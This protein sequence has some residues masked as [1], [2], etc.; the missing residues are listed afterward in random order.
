MKKNFTILLKKTFMLSAISAL[1]VVCF[2]SGYPEVKNSEAQVV[3]LQIEDEVIDFVYTDENS[4]E[5]LIIKTDEKT[6]FGL[7]SAQIYFSISNIGKNSELVNIQTYFPEDKVEIERIEKLTEDVPYE[8]DVPEFGEQ[9]FICEQGWEEFVEENE[10][11]NDNE[12]PFTGFVCSLTNEKEPCDSLSEDKKECLV[13]NVY[14]GTHKETKYKDDWTSL[15]FSKKEVSINESK[16]SSKVIKKKNSI[17]QNFQTRKPTQ[18][19]ADSGQTQYFRMEITFPLNSS[20]EFYIE[21]IGDQGAYGLLDPWWDSSWTYRKQI[22][23]DHDRVGI[24]S[25][26]SSNASSGQKQVVVKNGSAFAASETIVIKD[27][28]NEETGTISSISTNTLTMQSNLTNSYTTSANGF[29][30]NTTDSANLSNFPVLIN[31]SSD[32]SLALNAQDD[33]DDIA[34]TSSDETTQLDHEIESFNGTTGELQA[35]VE[36]PTLSTSTDTVLYMYYGNATCS[37]QE[38][39]SGVWDSNHKL[40]HHLDDLTT[41]TTEDSTSNSNDAAKRAANEPIE[42]TTMIGKG[43][44]FD[45]TND[46]DKVTNVVITSPSALTISSWIRKDSGGSTYETALHHAS[47]TTIGSSAYWLGVDVSDKL[48]ATIGATTGVGWAAG[49]TTSVATY[50][51]WYHLAAAWDGSV[52]KV[53]IDGEYNKQ[54]NLSTYTNW[55]TPTRFGASSDGSN[56]QFKGL[57]DEMR[58][59]TTSRGLDWIK[60]SY[61]NQKSPSSFFT[62]GPEIGSVAMTLHDSPFDNEE[63]PD[64]TPSFEFTGDDTIGS[65]DV[66]YQI[67]WDDNIS[68]SSPTTKTSDTDSGF[69]NTENGSDTSPFTEN[70]KINFTIQSGDA[71]SNSAANTSYYWRVRAK[72]DGG[73]YGEWTD[74]KSLRINTSLSS[75]QWTQTVDE[76]F[77]TGT[78]N[79]IKT[80]GS[81]S[82]ELSTGNDIQASR[83]TFTTPSATGNQTVT[84]V[85]FEPKAVMFEAVP[86]TDEN[87]GSHASHFF[88]FSDGSN[89]RSLTVESE[90]GANDTSRNQR[91]SAIYLMTYDDTVVARATVGSFNS[92]GFV[93]NYTVANSGYVIHYVA[94]GGD[95]LNAVVGTGTVSAG[96]VSGLSFEP[97]LVFLGTVGVTFE[98]GDTNGIIDFG[99]IN[100][101]NQWYAGATHGTNNLTKSSVITDDGCLAQTHADTA[102][103]QMTS[104][105]T[106]SSGFSWS[107]TNTD[108]FGYLALETDTSDTS[109]GVFQKETTGTSGAEQ[110]LSGWGF[111]N[112]A[113][114]VG[115]ASAGK[116]T[117]VGTSPPT[118]TSLTFGSYD[119]TNQGSI[120]VT[121]ERTTTDSDSVQNDDSVIGIAINDGSI[122]AKGTASDLTDDGVTL[123]W[124]PNN[125]SAYYLGYWAIESNELIAASGSLTST[126]IDY[127][128][129]SDMSSWDELSW[130]DSETTGDLKYQIQYWDGDSWELIPNESLTGNSTG[131]DTSPLDLSG[132]NTTTYNR[133]KIKANFTNSSGTPTL[134]DWTVSWEL[135]NNVPVVS[136]VSVNGGSTISL[137]EGTTVSVSWTST[138][139]DTDGYDDISSAEGVLY[140][141]GVSGAE[142]CSANQNNCYADSSC[143]LSGCSGNSCTATCTISMQFFTEPTDSGSP[144]PT[145]YWRGWVEA[146]DDF[147]ETGEAWSATGSPDVET[148]AAT[149]VTSVINYDPLLPGDDTGSSNET[150]TVTNTG[151]T[152]LDLEMSGDNFCTDYPT[153]SGSQIAVGYQEFYTSTFTYGLGTPLSSSPETV[154]ID[155][156]K[157]TSNPANSSTSIYW[158]MGVPNPKEDGG[159]SGAN[160]LLAV[161]GD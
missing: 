51:Q 138:V 26:L 154:Q 155:L 95:D 29:V 52:V 132:L 128:W 12:E 99:V 107:G 109:V 4:N 8:V 91:N 55:T 94:F 45:G 40:V 106:T 145:E 112:D 33:A 38:D 79:K 3:S 41:S 14:L 31:L 126:E 34:F 65:S 75:S 125:T 116:L 141:S 77:D 56:Y 118:G 24:I 59:S 80:T 98:G 62:L 97:D 17:P 70:Q 156:A 121:D 74:I 111:D 159:Y 72:K 135:S 113:A 100:S 86:R 25:E 69:T 87:V 47:G 131:F 37:S 110:T 93:L 146:T 19:L 122:I 15:K 151:N 158:G 89:H 82:V 36:V 78:F 137:T 103:W 53:Y 143:D 127:D 27:D 71:L 139:T 58:I 123:T 61:L 104:C 39:I 43:Q 90:D 96:S 50:G 44:S 30:K 161:D 60:T 67:E 68:F 48:T 22:T 108:Q 124:N 88:G 119:G 1:V 13:S 92:D 18:Y 9:I 23:I 120:T 35:W 152:I 85:G 7:G 28:N 81:D 66:I 21:A 144:Y 105:T 76:Q 32:T 46:Y 63:I 2:L 140:R 133:I 20:G 10:E 142:S 149:S 114:I 83:G 57:V 117:K 5:N 153:C 148:M 160:T 16:S 6:Y 102:T 49:Q 115:F 136:G 54:Y 134:Q 130:N 129:V 64:T 42:T 84:G 101:S 150:T 73:N 11:V 157:S 147:A